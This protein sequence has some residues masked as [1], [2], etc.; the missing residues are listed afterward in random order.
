LIVE[1]ARHSGARVLLPV[2]TIRP[3]ASVSWRDWRSPAGP[4]WPPW[5]RTSGWRRGDAAITGCKDEKLRSAVER[6]HGA[7]NLIFT[8]YDVMVRFHLRRQAA[9]SAGPFPPWRG[10]SGRV[11]IAELGR[12]N[13]I[14]GSSRREF[15]PVQG[16]DYTA[17]QLVSTSKRV[18]ER[19]L[20][21]HRAW[22]DGTGDYTG[23]SSPAGGRA[24]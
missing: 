21:V 10:A 20:E 4:I 13:L 1:T 2:A 22:P 14:M 9:E 15:R 3:S 7:R 18:R 8:N 19:R 11:L 12:T 23:R 5:A 16:S 17:A 6:R 24:L